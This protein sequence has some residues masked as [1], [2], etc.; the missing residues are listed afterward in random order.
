MRQVLRMFGAFALMLAPSWAFTQPALIVGVVEDSVGRAIPDVQVLVVGRDTTWLSD[1]RG[2]FRLGPLRA[3]TYVL[4]FRRLGYGPVTHVVEVP[5]A[6]TVRL[7]VELA[8]ASATLATV[9]VVG[10]SV[11][12]KLDR[13]GFVRRRLDG[14]IPASRFMARAEFEHRPPLTMTELL[15]RMGPFR[16]RCEEV[17]TFVDGVLMASRPPPDSTEK[18]ALQFGVS[19]KPPPLIDAIAPADVAAVEAYVSP[20]EIPLQYKAAGRGFDCVVLIWTRG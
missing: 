12:A 19:A 13:V 5:A 10:E 7:A 14:T 16:Q 8:P 2:G 9:R 15:G 11:A 17:A 3:A 1:A 18:K 4:Q 20:A 6:D